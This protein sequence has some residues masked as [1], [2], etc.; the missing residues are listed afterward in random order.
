[1]RMGNKK[2]T[3]K[4]ASS[5]EPLASIRKALKAF[6]FTA[7]NVLPKKQ[8]FFLPEKLQLPIPKTSK[9]QSFTFTYSISKHFAYEKIIAIFLPLLIKTLITAKQKHIASLIHRNRYTYRQ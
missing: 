8:S 7:S 2:N 4:R 6:L 5:H 9:N 3:K 1:M